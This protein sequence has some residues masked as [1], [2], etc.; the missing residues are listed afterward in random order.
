MLAGRAGRHGEALLL[1]L[2]LRD[3]GA[4]A[5]A[6]RHGLLPTLADHA[7]E[8]LE[9]DAAGGAA[10][11]AARWEE[12]PPARVV[13]SLQAAAAAAAGAE[14]QAEGGA[15]D[16]GC[17]AGVGSGQPSPSQRWRR[18]LHEYTDA[19]F[20]QDPSA[21]AEFGGLQVELYAEFD[22][23]RLLP[24]LLASPHYPLEHAHQVRRGAVVPVVPPLHA[25]L[26]YTTLLEH[27]WVPRNASNPVQRLP[28]GWC[29][30]AL[31]SRRPCTLNP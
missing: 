14:P 22:P 15:S 31:W 9:A 24:F 5:Y 23:G 21:G 11:L 3:P 12:A 29:A 20:A 13:A 25:L 26:H 2:Q 19:L 10:L 1:L 17:T 4:G 28:G 27:A 16:A 18:A 8:L 30:R 6:Q 7:A